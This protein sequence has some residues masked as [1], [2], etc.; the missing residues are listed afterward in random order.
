KATWADLEP[1]AAGL[2]EAERR[3]VIQ[4]EGEGV[5]LEQAAANLGL[6]AEEA[7]K[8]HKRAMFKLRMAYGRAKKSA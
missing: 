7:A 4:V 1:F 8:L 3:L 6:T 2:E 5:P